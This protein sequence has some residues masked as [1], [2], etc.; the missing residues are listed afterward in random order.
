MKLTIII[1]AYNEE[2]TVGQVIKA[3][4][5]KI[6]G[7]KTI[8]VVVV[9][10]GSTDQT[11]KE[12]KEAG[13]VVLSHRGRRG[14]AHTFTTGL[15]WAMAQKSDLIVTIDGDNQYNPREIPNLVSP[16]ILHEADLMIGNRQI[17]KLEHMS[18]SKKLANI[19]GTFMVQK[20][21]QTKIA[22]ASSGF[23][24]FTAEVGRNLHILS[25][26]TY[27]H[28]MIIQAAHKKFKLTSIPVTFK[29]R[30]HGQSRLIESLWAHLKKSS[31][32]ILRT[33]LMYQPF[34]TFLYLGSLAIFTGGALGLRFLLFFLQSQGSGHIQSLILAAVLVIVGFNTIIM[35]FLADLISRNRQLH[36]KILEKISGG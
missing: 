15:D 8:K 20:L 3:I 23:R 14:L 36:E 7:V 31:A 25:S 19:F 10:D 32:T 1:P 9:D 6:N 35:G 24:A 13:A 18:L 21:T 11:A 30:R 2:A 22:D 27:T 5:Q 16:L 33:L 29:A 4:P 34:K 26:H 28:E 17:T 12:A